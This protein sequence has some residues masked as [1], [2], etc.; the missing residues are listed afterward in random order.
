MDRELAKLYLKITRTP[1]IGPATFKKAILHFKSARAIKDASRNEL[2]MVLS[3]VVEEE[4]YNRL[5]SDDPELDRELDRLE[6]YGSRMILFEDPEYPNLLREINMPPPFLYAKGKITNLNEPMIA[7]V[8][9]RRPTIHGKLA[10][11]KICKELVKFGFTVVSGF[12]QGIDTIAHRSVLECGGKSVAVFGCGV[13]RVYPASNNWLYKEILEKGAVISEFPPGTPPR[14]YNFPRRN[15]IISGISYG[16]VIVEAGE[17]SGALITANYAIDQN[18]ELFAVPGP[19]GSEK[20]KGVNKLIELGATPVT[21]GK[22]VYETLAPII[23][24]KPFEPEKVEQEKGLV[25]V[26]KQNGLESRILSI[27]VGSPVH[28]DD[29]AHQLGISVRDALS[30]LFALELKGLVKQ[31]PGKYYI[32]A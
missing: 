27:M 10:T 2:R 18:R 22:T 31:L 5:N 25:Q 23:D 11:E 12:A 1:G 6:A 3:P 29:I 16:T 26:Q 15:R 30:F 20:S 9:T 7:V 24:I 8:G 28:I 19:L 4:L 21:D 14:S 17:K 32:K 13:D